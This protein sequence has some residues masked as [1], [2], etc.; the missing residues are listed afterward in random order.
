[1]PSSSTSSSQALPTAAGWRLPRALTPVVFA[2][3]MAGI[4]A[5]LMSAVIVA[6]NTGFG[7]G[8]VQRVLHAYAIAMPAAFLSVMMVRP[9]VVRLVGWTVR[10]A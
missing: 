5:F 2:F 4:M 3:Y 10:A 1:M 7:A 6:A 8:F 9:V